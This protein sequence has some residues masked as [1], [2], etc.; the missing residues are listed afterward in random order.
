M[1]TTANIDFAEEL[2]ILKELHEDNVGRKFTDQQFNESL[3]L[4]KSDQRIY[5]NIAGIL[6]VISKD[7]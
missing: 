6:K 5:G 2:T 7:I 1:K 3:Q 4:L